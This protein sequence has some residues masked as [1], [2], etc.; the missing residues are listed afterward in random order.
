MNKIC[1][2]NKDTKECVKVLFDTV[3]N[4]TEELIQAPQNEGEIGWF[5][6]ENGWKTYEE[7]CEKQRARRDKYLSVYVDTINAV[8]WNSMNEQEKNNW[9]QYRKDL[10]D[11]PQQ[12]N[13]PRIINWPSKPE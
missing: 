10:L 11:I 9:I 6:N 12:L 13:F 7:W 8:R 1:V 3:W 4:D 2:I 5:W